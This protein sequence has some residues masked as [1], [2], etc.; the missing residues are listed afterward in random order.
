M[1]GGRRFGYTCSG[2]VDTT[3][4]GQ[5]HEAGPSNMLTVAVYV[6][7]LYTIGTHRYTYMRARTHNSYI[8]QTEQHE[9]EGQMR[10]LFC[11][12]NVTNLLDVAPSN[13][14]P[15]PLSPPPIPLCVI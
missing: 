5:F 3:S 12:G 9:P 10:M 1:I 15:H 11:L 2:E 7:S 8:P 4:S 6:P 13:Q 14:I